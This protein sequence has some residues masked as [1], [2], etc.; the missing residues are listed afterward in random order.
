MRRLILLMTIACCVSCAPAYA[1]QAATR[2]SLA[3]IS[4]RAAIIPPGIR[5]RSTASSAPISR[6][7]S[8]AP[9]SYSEADWELTELT[10]GGCCP[11]AFWAADSREVRFLARPEASQPASIYGV[12]PTG[13]PAK[14]VRREPALFSPG[15]VYIVTAAGE[16]VVVET[17]SD[18]KRWT[19]ATGGRSVVFSHSMQLVAWAESS[20]AYTNLNLIQ[21]T[22]WVH[23]L[24]SG[25]S[26]RVITIVGG[27]LLGWSEDDASVFVSG[28]LVTGGPRGV[29]RASLA[30]GEPE[31]LFEADEIQGALLSPDGS[32]LA[33]FTAFGS[34]TEGNGLWV[35]SA[36]DG[37]AKRLNLFGSYRW[38][39]E[40][41]LLI[42][43]LTLDPRGDALWEY[44]AGGGSL[45]LLL[46]PA[47]T[48]FKVADND[49]SVSPDGRYVAFRSSVDHNIWT[50]RLPHD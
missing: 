12:P 37:A 5:P 10:R 15:D 13:G 47:Q 8:T 20:D 33:F 49:W 45:S 16:D 22:V 41:R 11:G 34:D 28:G 1:S 7:T 25:Q 36:S 6:G 44:D 2:P 21:R 29:W 18:G 48:S 23:D 26:A 40:D 3:K 38:R 35:M 31:F 32:R 9:P 30:G 50:L 46:P 43:P 19:V 42:I 17:L 4:N 27:W 14:L 39:G 24:E